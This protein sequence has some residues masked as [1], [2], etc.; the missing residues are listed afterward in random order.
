MEYSN[1]N[2]DG[3][4]PN[5]SSLDRRNVTK[6]GIKYKEGFYIAEFLIEYWKDDVLVKGT[7]DIN[8]IEV[9]KNQKFLGFAKLS[10]DENKSIFEL[11]SNKGKKYFTKCGIE[12]YK[13]SN[14]SVT[15]F[16][17]FDNE[18]CNSCPFKEKVSRVING[19]AV[20]LFEC[21]AGEFEPSKNNTY[22]TNSKENY[23]HLSIQ[24]IDWDWIE[25]LRNYS[26]TVDGVTYAYYTQDLPD[27]RKVLSISFTQNKKGIAAKRNII[28]K[29]FKD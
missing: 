22:S 4:I 25:S 14:A 8:E 23:T 21:R 6:K 20:N 3:S 9:Y 27:C 12:F 11:K 10:K 5:I 15:G 18:K 2:I 24:S 29:Y 17:C 16:K 7:E 19:E 13:N 28:D 26:I 1:K